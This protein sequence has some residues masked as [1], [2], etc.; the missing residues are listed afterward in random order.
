MRSTLHAFLV[1]LIAWALLSGA[2]NAQDAR[3]HVQG[4]V[5]DSSNAV[6]VGA[7]VTLFNTKTGVKM[8]RPTN[9]TGLYRF[10]YVDPGTYTITVEA[11]GFSRFS[12]E[13]FDIQAQADVTVNASLKLGGV[14]ESVTVGGSIV[15]LQFNTSNHALT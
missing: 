13:T 4:L 7:S 9:E 6:I 8:V 2:M 15:E 14:T 12:Q 11:A 3:A 1:T 5:T 10:D